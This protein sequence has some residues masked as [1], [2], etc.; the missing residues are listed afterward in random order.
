MIEFEPFGEGVRLLV[1]E[2][3]GIDRHQLVLS[4]DMTVTAATALL[5]RIGTAIDEA[6]VNIRNLQDKE[7]SDRLRRIEALKSEL[8]RLE[9]ANG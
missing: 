9:A 2:R 5:A 1:R 3:D 6:K 4:Q 7:R 8:A